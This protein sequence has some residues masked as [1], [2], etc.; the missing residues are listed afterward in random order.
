M[1][2]VL[3]RIAT[4]IATVQPVGLAP[5]ADFVAAVP[6]MFQYAFHLFPLFT[7]TVT[8]RL[9]CAAWASQDWQRCGRPDAPTTRHYSS[10]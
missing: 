5:M 4:Q 3:E 6:L 2:T 9:C 7:D 8:D 1:V 10:C